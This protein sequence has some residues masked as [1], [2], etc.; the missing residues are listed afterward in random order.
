MV[1][2]NVFVSFNSVTNE[3]VDYQENMDIPAEVSS[4]L[5]T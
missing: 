5:G 1:A 2:K 3:E 4:P